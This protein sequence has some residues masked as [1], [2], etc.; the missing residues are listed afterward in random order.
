MS[1][2]TQELEVGDV[3]QLDPSRK[4]LWGPVFAVG[5]EIRDWGVIANM[6]I[7]EARAAPPGVAPIRLE[8]GSFVRI[9]KA[10]WIMAMR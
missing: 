9:G 7:P 10:A 6:Y 5:E 2:G 8:K 3:I 1:P 4:A